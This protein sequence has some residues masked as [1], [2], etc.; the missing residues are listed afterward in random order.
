MRIL[1]SQ[2]FCFSHICFVRLFRRCKNTEMYIAPL[3]ADLCAPRTPFRCRIVAHTS[4]AMLVRVVAAILLVLCLRSLTEISEAIIC[5]YA[6]LVINLLSGIQVV[7]W[8]ISYFPLLIE[9]LDPQAV[10]MFMFTVSLSFCTYTS[11]L[12]MGSSS[13]LNSPCR[14]IPLG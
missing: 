3:V 1:S 5:A 8:F 2:S 11:H 6:V 7:N 9:V 13:L 14:E 12:R 10:Y 4:Q